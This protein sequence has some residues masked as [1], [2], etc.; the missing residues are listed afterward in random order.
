[1]YS[2]PGRTILTR[3]IRNNTAVMAALSF[4]SAEFAYDYRDLDALKAAFD[5]PGSSGRQPGSAPASAA[6]DE[7]G[8]ET[9]EPDDSD[10]TNERESAEP[11]ASPVVAA[12][13]F[14]LQ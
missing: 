9:V 11:A 12:L 13:F 4:R 8:R 5:H 10:E 6:P 7:H 14:E 2:E 1:M 3:A